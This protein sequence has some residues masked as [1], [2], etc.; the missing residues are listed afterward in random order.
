MAG[1]LL[2]P[3]TAGVAL[4]AAVPL[5]TDVSL[6]NLSSGLPLSLSLTLS[7]LHLATVPLSLSLC[8]QPRPLVEEGLE[9]ESL[10]SL[11]QRL[12]ECLS[13]SLKV[14]SRLLLL[15]DGVVGARLAGQGLLDVLGLLDCLELLELGL[16]VV[17]GLLLLGWLLLELVLLEL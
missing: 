15:L 7:S 3:L 13:L 9:V 6:V 12:D 2:P 8:T 17:L 10:L 1:S 11:V 14:L 5:S 4:G 16:E